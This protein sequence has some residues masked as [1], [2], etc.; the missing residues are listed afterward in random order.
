MSYEQMQSTMQFIL[1]QQAQYSTRLEKDEEQI[2]ELRS[3]FVT[4]TELARNS[5]ERIDSFDERM[6]ALEEHLKT[7]I[8]SLH[9]FLQAQSEDFYA[10]LNANKADFDDRLT[11]SK[12]D[13]DAR[14]IAHRAEFEFQLG[15]HYAGLDQRLT[16]QNTEFAQ[17]FLLLTEQASKTEQRLD[18][19]SS[20]VEHHLMKGSG[21]K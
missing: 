17:R 18:R 14:L 10:R 11:A 5:D 12:A 9:A 21:E 19:L 7:Q 15:A 2:T 20:L 4:L 13:F 1:E 3:A 16:G 6:N 8:E